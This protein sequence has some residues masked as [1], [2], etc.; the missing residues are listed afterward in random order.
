MQA[1]YADWAERMQDLSLGSIDFGIKVC[2]DMP[3]PPSKGEFFNACRGYN[4]PQLL[5]IESKLSPEQ[6]EANKQRMADIAKS[7]ARSKQA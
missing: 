4:P 5:K 3:H 6:R 7:L 1:V 2:G